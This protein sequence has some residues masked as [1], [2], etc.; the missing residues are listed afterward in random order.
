MMQKKTKI[1]GSQFK[2]DDLGYEQA[3]LEA[4]WNAKMVDRYPDLIIQA[5]NQQ[6]VIEAIFSV[7]SL[8]F[9]SNTFRFSNEKRPSSVEGI[10]STS[11]MV[12]N[13]EV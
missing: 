4:T 8:Y 5:N 13:Q 6:E 12:S 2:R 11:A 1:R 3:R 10:T 7:R 9:S